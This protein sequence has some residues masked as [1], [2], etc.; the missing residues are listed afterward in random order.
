MALVTHYDLELYQ[1]DLKIVFLYE[2]LND[3]YMD[4]PMGFIKEGKEHMVCKLNSI[5]SLM[6]LLGPLNLRKTLLIDVYI[7]RSVGASLYF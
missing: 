1:M 4:Q 2:N 3:V 7:Q 6:I 5:L